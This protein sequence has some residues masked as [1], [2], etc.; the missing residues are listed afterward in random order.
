MNK[1][2][3][4]DAHGRDVFLFNDL[5]LVSK[6]TGKAAKAAALAASDKARLQDAT[7]QYREA[8]SLVNL[9]VLRALS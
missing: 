5:V 6:A 1:R 8:H 3:A 2:Q 4:E 9:Q 7:Y